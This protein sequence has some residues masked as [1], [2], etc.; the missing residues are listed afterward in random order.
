[1][2][3]VDRTKDELHNF[4]PKNHLEAKQYNIYNADKMHGLPIGVQVVGRRL[5]EEKVLE[6]MK[7]VE[8]SLQRKG[9]AYELLD[10]D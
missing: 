5:E 3:H 7:V 9:E 10:V 1:V 8:S 6:G 2:T 4:K